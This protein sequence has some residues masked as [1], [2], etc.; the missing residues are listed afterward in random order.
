MIAICAMILPG[1]S[2]AFILLILGKYEYVTS[3]L[4]NPFAGQNILIILVFAAGAIVGILSFSRL[5]NSL[6]KK[7]HNLTIAILTGLMAG[8]L[9]KI[10]PWKQTLETVTIRGKV[11]VLREA[12]IL[13]PNY[14]SA[15]YLSLLLIL[16][17]FVLVFA[18]EK[19]AGRPKE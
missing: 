11:H 10:W 4:K 8:S 12:N 13:P 6:L 3:A 14:D 15:F 5:L 17:G 19:M 18:L 16:V 9:R 7:H 2:G 1:I